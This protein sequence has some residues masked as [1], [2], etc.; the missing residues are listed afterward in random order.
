MFLK[1]CNYVLR[2]LPILIYQYIN[3]NKLTVFKV[4][5]LKNSLIKMF[6]KK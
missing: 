1:L 2:V 3:F 5:V 4:L 6:K